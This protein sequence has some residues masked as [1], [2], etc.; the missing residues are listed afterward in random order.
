MRAG[1]QDSAWQRLVGF[2]N[3]KIRG[4]DTIPAN[5]PQLVEYNI[6]LPKHIARPDGTTIFFFADLHWN[7]NPANLE[8]VHRIVKATKP[9]WIVFG[10]DLTTYACHLD[11]AFEWLRTV[12]APFSDIP[13]LAV[14][15]NWDRRR[16]KWLPSAF[17]KDRYA[18]AG[19]EFLVN[20]SLESKGVL[21]HGLDETRGGHP[22]VAPANAVSDRL[23]CWISHSV[24]FVVEDLAKLSPPGANLALC[25]HSHGGQIRLPLF[26]ALT[27][28]TKYWK[29]FEYG[30]YRLRQGALD[31]IVTS[32]LGKSRLPIRLLCPPEVVVVR[33]YR[34]S[35]ERGSG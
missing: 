11:G 21:F 28:S 15:G 32:G 8:E 10:G 5:I 19:F 29:K 1:V 14:P 3:R 22:A 20:R 12:F 24:D 26:G 27:T 31:M 4:V 2:H 7:D 34:K 25:G 13:K 23:N 30:H 16:K 9:D 35:R 6:A 18:Q 33:V 17:W